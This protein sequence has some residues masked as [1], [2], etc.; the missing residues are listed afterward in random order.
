MVLLADGRITG[1]NN[2]FPEEIPADVQ[3]PQPP[4]GSEK[5]ASVLAAQQAPALGALATYDRYFVK[6]SITK[7]AKQLPNLVSEDA[8]IEAQGWVEDLGTVFRNK[9]EAISRQIGAELPHQELGQL[10]MESGN[11]YTVEGRLYLEDYEGTYSFQDMPIP[12]EIEYSVKRATP[13][14]WQNFLFG[15][16]LAQHRPTEPTAGQEI[17]AEILS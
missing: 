12:E 13:E 16:L 7:T 1:E 4:I 9:T 3:Q 2:F 10:N 6:Q 5:V 11:F 14:Q 17:S 15:I 8:R